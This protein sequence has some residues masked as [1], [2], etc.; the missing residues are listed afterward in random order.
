M[1]KLS[2]SVIYYASGFFGRCTYLGGKV[3][4]VEGP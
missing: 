4:G 2:A 3:L 1:I